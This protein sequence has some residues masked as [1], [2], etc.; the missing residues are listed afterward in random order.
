MRQ[1]LVA[2]ERIPTQPHPELPQVL[3]RF[4]AGTQ[5]VLGDNFVGAYLVGSLATGDFDNDSDVDFVVILDHNLDEGEVGGPEAL[6]REIQNLGGYP[7]RHLEGSYISQ[8]LLSR[9]DLVGVQPVWYVD[10]GATT[11][12]RSTH[13]NQWHVRWILRERG[14][15]LAGPDPKLLIGPVKK[16]ALRTEMRTSIQE[17]GTHFM[18]ELDKP[19]G[20]FNSRFGQSFT[21]LTCC[22]MLHTFHTGEIQSKLAAVRWAEQSVSPEW[23]ELIRQSWAERK[24]AGL[25]EK[26]D[27]LAEPFL[28][29]ETARFVA[30]VESELWSHVVAQSIAS[31]LH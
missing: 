31:G 21:V 11:L 16:E 24:G 23:D 2:T 17:L 3:D 9:I 22:R 6:H 18:A 12:T 15:V 30:F 8:P 25:G 27:Q 14:I 19:L 10:N 4:V 7:A 5:N 29:H 20:W 1:S 13:D 28:L 26:V